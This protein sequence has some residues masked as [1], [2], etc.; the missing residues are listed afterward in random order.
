VSETTRA[1]L[2]N[3]LP[4]GAQVHDLGEQHLKDIQH[5]HIYEI[6]IDGAPRAAKPLKTERAGSMESRLEARI[7]AYVEQQI[8]QAFA[9][10]S[11]VKVPMKP[12]AGGFGVLLMLVVVVV[13]IV[14]LVKLVF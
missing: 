3:Q 11:E 9:D 2:G 5:E 1:L 7:S 10:P 12:V 13:V 8:E 4:D 6:S 14:L